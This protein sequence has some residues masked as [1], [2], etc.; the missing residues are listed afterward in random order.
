MTTLIQ[1]KSGNDCVL[2]AIA[3]A[4]GKDKWEDLWT[5]E[6]LQSVIDSRGIN[7]VDPWM[8][9]AGFEREKHFRE[10]FVYSGSERIASALLWR[11]R[12]LLSVDSLNNHGGSHMIYWDGQ[13]IWDPH[14]GHYPEFLAFRH[15]TSCK[16]NRVQLFADL[17]G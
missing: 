7:D 8:L 16:I 12:A 15:L 17:T 5:P 10:I 2:A 1:Q 4:A 14:E 11:R 3:M 6:D 13:K 9:R